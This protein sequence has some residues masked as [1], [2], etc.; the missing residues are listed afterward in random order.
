MFLSFIINLN[1]ERYNLFFIQKLFDLHSTHDIDGL[2]FDTI[3]DV[4]H[5]DNRTQQV[6]TEPQCVKVLLTEQFNM[7][8]QEILGNM[9]TQWNTKKVKS[10]LTVQ[11]IKTQKC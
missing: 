6:H 10:F 8:G 9:K 3:T 4:L 2:S 1:V 11:E 7:G 5:F